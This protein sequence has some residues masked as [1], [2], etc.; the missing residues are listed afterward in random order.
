LIHA[1]SNNETEETGC[2]V[3][4]MQ[5]PQLEKHANHARAWRDWAKV[6]YTASVELFDSGNPDR[7]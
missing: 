4:A 2:S 5:S 6:N 3:A 1:P 7:P